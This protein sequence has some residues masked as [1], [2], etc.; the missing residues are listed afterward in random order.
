MAGTHSARVGK[1][2]PDGSP[3]K[4]PVALGGVSPP[5]GLPPPLPPL[6]Q[7][8]QF[9]Y[10]GVKRF[11]AVKVKFIPGK[12]PVLLCYDADETLL[13]TQDIAALDEA[14]IADLLA[15][16]TRGFSLKGSGGI[17]AWLLVLTHIIA[18]Q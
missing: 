9:V 4:P 12:S 15:D 13:A 7:V 16:Y 3:Q 18:A 14:G 11:P 10:E 6:P 17:I 5:P 2:K 1:K 8:R